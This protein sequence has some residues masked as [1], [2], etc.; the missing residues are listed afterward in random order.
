[1]LKPS[2]EPRGRALLGRTFICLTVTQVQIQV[3]A[4]GLL[5]VVHLCLPVL[6]TFACW[7]HRV[8]VQVDLRQCLGEEMATP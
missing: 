8:T 7:Q 1:M 5:F 2:N 6:I 4:Q 3:R